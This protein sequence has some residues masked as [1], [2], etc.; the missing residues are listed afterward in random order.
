LKNLF[1]KLIK[2]FRPT[3]NHNTMKI[4]IIRK[5]FKNLTDDEFLK[6]RALTLD[7]SSGMNDVLDDYETDEH[8]EDYWKDTCAFVAIASDGEWVGW[9]LGRVSVTSSA[10]TYMVFV[11]PELRRM[12]IGKALIKVATEHYS[13][14]GYANQCYPWDKTS[15]AFFKSLDVGVQLFSFYTG[16][17]LDM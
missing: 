5:S 12:G 7:P 10:N 16:E 1:Q 3:S 14:T 11:K 2:N 13:T 8:Y 4:Q 9:C 15:T 6:L 17:R